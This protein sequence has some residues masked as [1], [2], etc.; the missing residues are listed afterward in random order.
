M[1]DESDITKAIEGLA[2]K[3]R[4]AETVNK[5]HRKTIDTLVDKA[6]Q[7]TLRITELD[8]ERQTWIDTAESREK[9]LDLYKNRKIVGT[10]MINDYF[11]KIFEDVLDNFLG[12]LHHSKKSRVEELMALTDGQRKE[13]IQMR[14]EFEAMIKATIDSYTKDLGIPS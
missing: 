7:Q 11:G 9:E 8:D 4:I 10:E 5:K 6:N 12:H 1:I 2:D 3:L 14:T 13:I